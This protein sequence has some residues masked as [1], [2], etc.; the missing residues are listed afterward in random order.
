MKH[1]NGKSK[2][3]IFYIFTVTLLYSSQILSD[4][5]FLG[6]VAE[7]REKQQQLEIEQRR[8]ELQRERI[9]NQAKLDRYEQKQKLL[10]QELDLCKYLKEDINAYSNCIAKVMKKKN[11]AL[12]EYLNQN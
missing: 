7:Q 6:G 2:F 5:F 10:D 1:S 4:G 9:N 12:D 11:I 8:L 3:C